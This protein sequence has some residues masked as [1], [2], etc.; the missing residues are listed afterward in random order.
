MPG[1]RVRSGEK[2]TRQLCRQ[3][4]FD[5]SGRRSAHFKLRDV[6]TTAQLSPQCDEQSCFSSV[7]ARLPR[8]CWRSA[9]PVPGRRLHIASCRRRALSRRDHRARRSAVAAPSAH[10]PGNQ[11]N[12]FWPSAISADSIYAGDRR[13]AA[14]P[15]KIEFRVPPINRRRVL[16]GA[17]IRG[18]PTRRCASVELDVG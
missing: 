4:L 6:P 10:G 8:V 3:L 7:S 17:S 1:K 2:R 11:F 12:L 15:N 13:S 14:I 9:R 18:G 16:D 5:E